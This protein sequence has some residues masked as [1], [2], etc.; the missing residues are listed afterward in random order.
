VRL[1]DHGIR[2]FHP[3]LSIRPLGCERG[4]RSITGDFQFQT[5]AKKQHYF[6]LIEIE[7]DARL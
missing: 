6:M 2:S 4:I 1:K 3:A 5:M 7:V